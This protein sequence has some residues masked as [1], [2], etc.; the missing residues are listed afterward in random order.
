MTLTVRST[1]DVF[2]NLS[3]ALVYDD[4]NVLSGNRVSGEG[5]GEMRQ[6]T[7][8]LTDDV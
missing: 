6:C 5:C 1:C 3:S 2:I 4:V 8:T 7:H